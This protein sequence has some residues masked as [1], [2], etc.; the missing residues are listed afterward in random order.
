M[1]PTYV[2]DGGI[3]MWLNAGVKGSLAL[4]LSI[5]FALSL[6]LPT[7]EA[8]AGSTHLKSCP[9]LADLEHTFQTSL[10][11]DSKDKKVTDWK[12]KISMHN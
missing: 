11:T 6:Y 7:Q 5:S 12:K 8:Q 4:S 2:R 1:T 3:S 9:I 10:Q